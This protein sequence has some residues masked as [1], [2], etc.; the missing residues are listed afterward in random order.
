MNYKRD[1]LKASSVKY[2]EEKNEEKWAE[3]QDLLR[4]HPPHCMIDT[5]CC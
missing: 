5:P 4:A 2:T 3:S 1:N